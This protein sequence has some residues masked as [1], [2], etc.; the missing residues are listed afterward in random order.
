MLCRSAW[1]RGIVHRAARLLIDKA[2]GEHDLHKIWL[3]VRADNEKAAISGVAGFRAEVSSETNT[4]SMIASTWSDLGSSRAISKAHPLTQGEVPFAILRKRLLDA[5]QRLRSYDHSSS[6]H[7]LN[8]D[9]EPLVLTD[10][11]LS[12]RKL[13]H[14]EDRG[15]HSIKRCCKS[16]VMPRRRPGV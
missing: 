1:G 6:P 8:A 3:I 12:C 10:W 4:G 9:G 13:H 2:F 15:T 14:I 7:N 16:P 11:T 5:L